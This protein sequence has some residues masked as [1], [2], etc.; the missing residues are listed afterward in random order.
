MNTNYYVKVS[1]IEKEDNQMVDEG[2]EIESAA[3]AIYVGTPDAAGEIMH[4]M[5]RTAQGLQDLTKARE[6]IIRL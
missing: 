4:V 3:F 5:R 2:K 1:V 6:L